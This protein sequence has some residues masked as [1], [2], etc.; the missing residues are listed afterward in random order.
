[1]S[2]NLY[3]TA[4]ELAAA[5][6]GGDVSSTELT[7]AYIERIE[8]LDG[9]INA[10]VV[11]RFDEAMSEAR[12]ADEA[13]ARG[14]NR[15]PLH[16]VPVSIKESYDLAGT[17]TTWGIPDFADNIAA[18][19]SDTV[20]RLK[21]AGA[22]FLGKTNVP[23][24]LA[25]FQ[26][27]NDIYGTTNNP[28]DLARTP[29]GSSGGS[30]AALAAGFTAL[31]AG[32]DIGGSIRNP[33]HFCG[34][35]GHK[36]T[37]GI[38]SDAGH[39]LPGSAAPAD[40]AV[41]GPLARSAEDLALALGIVAGAGERDA[42]GW[43]LTLPRP[44]KKSLAEFRV[45]LWPEADFAPVDAEVSARVHEVAEV[46]ARAGA[47]VSDSARPAIDINK[48]L[49]TYYAL[50]WGVLG[51]G[52]S[53]ETHQKRRDEA[54]SLA[55][56]DNSPAARVARFAT[57]DHRAWL[58]HH[59]RRFRLRDAWQAFF[60]DWDILI[61]PQMPTPAFP[62]DQSSQ[63]SRR[64]GINGVD[65]PYFEQLHWAGLIT[66]AHLPSTVFP[67]GPSTAGLPIG[68]QAVGREY[69]DLT[70]IEFCRLLGAETGGFTPP[71]AYR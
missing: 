14:D 69:D 57:Q 5:I 13:L 16:G 65:T 51:A 59:H 52:V 61:C 22:H 48:A 36:P 8:R 40:I 33:A 12:A 30:S 34:V 43:S 66:V 24:S 39:A 49:D 35:Y 46:L 44:Q 71:P 6:R 17:P 55:P 11:R 53:D 27:Y 56:D 63:M 2:I 70:C 25:D 50:L 4:T 23:F 58:K 32:S 67:S 47:T 28:W 64:I 7:A 68:L 62:H 45:A 37:W 10:M 29:G 60:A 18:S 54:A 15:G 31:E 3:A 26:S 38:V 42:S 9:D 19:D 21:A 1:M 20:R 41:C